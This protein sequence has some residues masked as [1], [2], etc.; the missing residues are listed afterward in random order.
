VKLK[1]ILTWDHY[2][3]LGVFPKS[4]TSI[5]VRTIIIFIVAVV[6][7]VATAQTLSEQSYSGMRWR[8]VGPFRAGRAIAAAGIPGNPYVFYFGSVDGGM[9]K[10]E[11][12]GVTWKSISDGLTNPSVGAIDIAPSN[13]SIIYVGT[14]EADL[15]S[16]I[17]YGGGVYKSTD[18]GSH[19]QFVGLNGT[20]HI[21]RVLIDPRNPDVVL[22]AAV[23]HAYGPNEERGVFRTTDGG[24]NWTKVLYKNPDVGAVDLATDPQEPSIVYATMW[25]ARRT[26]WSQYPPNEG[27]GSGLY[28]S[29][30]EGMTWS[31]MTEHGLPSKPYG[32]IGVSVASGTHGKIVYALINAQK[33]GSGLYRSDDSGESWRL[34]SKDDNIIARMWYFAG[35]TVNPQD[36]NSVFVP[37]RSLMRSTDGGKTFS[38]IKGAPGGD[39]YHFLWVDPQNDQRMILASDQGTGVSVDGGKTWSSWYNQPT[40]QFYHVAVDNQFPYRIYGSQQDMGTTSITSRSDFGQISFRDWYSVGGEE[41]GYIAP[42]PLNPNIVYGGGPYGGVTRYDHMTGQSRVISPSVLASFTTPANQRK[43]RFTWTSP[44]VFNRRDPHILYLGSQRLLETRNGGLHWKEISPDL[45]GADKKMMDKKGPPTIDDASARG[46]GVIYTI[47]PSPLRKGMIWVGTDD[48]LIRLTEDDGQHWQ[49]VTPPGLPAWS[50]ISLIEASP[51]EAGEAY[52]AVDRHRLDD[53]APYIYVTKDY[54]KHWSRADKGIGSLSYVQDV[55]SDLTR[56]GLLYAGTETGVY[57]S[58]D[59]GENWQSLQLNL[60]TASV[61]DLA[62]HD[63]DL[64]AATHGRAFWVLDNLTPLQQL[65][66]NVVA[67]EAYLFQPERTIRI[68]RSENRDTPLPPEEPLGTNPPNGAIIDYYLHSKPESPISLEIT[69]ESGNLVRQFSSTDQ[70]EPPEG[71]QYFMNE[72]L[73]KPQPLTT[74]TGHNRFV[75]DLHYTPPPSRQYGYSMAAIA[76]LGTEKDPLGPLVLPGKYSVKLTVNGHSSTQSLVV[77]MDPRVHIADAALKDQLSL[78]IDVWNAMADEFALRAASDTLARQLVSLQ[79]RTDTDT[80]LRSEIQSFDKKFAEFRRTFS[81]GFSG[82]ET[83]IMGADREPT[84]QMREAFATLNT[85]LSDSKKEWEELKS[86]DLSRL[87]NKLK[88]LGLSLLEMFETAAP[89]LTMNNES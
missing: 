44:I 62:V 56:K 79:H 48:G 20:R 84:Q 70:A 1:S 78:A 73:P 21:G 12:A 14:G 51:F 41:S 34:T 86:R 3:R 37:N 30:D 63:N 53:F 83:T 5:I 16:D 9:W 26:P 64:V 72:W 23:G 57:V 65:D 32:R 87:N 36:P 2:S 82:L 8:L 89:H 88:T 7:S 10:T 81:G 45:T 71:P 43:Y 27:P 11:N 31:E 28:K 77:A 74:Q 18:G 55:R 35:I 25:Q 67:S 61:R 40:G 46:W 75:W 60:P 59:D 66:E 52:A 54:G 68:R 33:D 42:D 47:A 80:S 76:H 49:N 19:W 50:K 17:T 24:K 69:D 13:P 15:R 85:K 38:V 6:T 4:S 22:V 29:T 58:F 39:D